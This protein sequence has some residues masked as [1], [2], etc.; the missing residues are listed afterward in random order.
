MP[1]IEGY[2]QMKLEDY[3]DEI[4]YAVS[5]V[6]ESIWHEKGQSSCIT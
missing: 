1:L 6:I 2:D 4:K 5:R 3:L